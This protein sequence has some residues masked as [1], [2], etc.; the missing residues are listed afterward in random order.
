MTV[1]STRHL[2]LI[3]PECFYANRETMQTNIYQVE[4]EAG[5]RD[6]VY[7]AA[8]HEFR[9]FRN[10]LVENG[11]FVTTMRGLPNCPDNLFPNWISTHEN[12]EMVVY[13]MLNESRQW[14]RAPDVIDFINYHYDMA[15]DLRDYEK[16]GRALEATGSLNLD[17]VNKIAYVALSDR[18]DPDLAKIWCDKMGYELITFHTDTGSGQPVYHSDLVFWI[19][20]DVAAIC[21]DCISDEVERERVLDSLKTH[22]EVV[23]LSMGQLNAF[24]GNSLEILGHDEARMLIMSDAAHNAL[25]PDQIEIFAKYFSKLLS[26]PIPTIEKYGGGSARCMIMELF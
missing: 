21:A 23:E 18:T 1:Q 16:E 12:R 13:P 26:S 5:D 14:E 6:E 9:V 22:R 25:R 3:E 10:L 20:T 8:L 7:A 4:E 24:C 11:V 17:R 19:G 2:L 15:L